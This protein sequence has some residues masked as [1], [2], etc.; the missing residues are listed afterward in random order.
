MLLHL[1]R[2]LLAVLPIAL[3]VS[4]ICFLLVYLAP[5]DPLQTLL[6]P[7]ADAETVAKLKQ[8]YGLDRPLPLQYL[9]WLWQVM[10]GDLGQSIATGRPVLSE[11]RRSLGNTVLL[12]A[13]AVL[14]AFPLAMLLGTIAGY[15]SGGWM[16]RGV[17]G[18]AILGVS[19]PNYWLGIVLVILFS[20]ELGWLPA[21]GMGPD[22]SG[23]FNP[24]HWEQLRHIILPVVTLSMIPVGIIARTAR[25]S[26][27]EVMAQDFVTTL[28]ANGLPERRVLRHA[29]KNALPSVL[30]VMGLQ[31][32]ALMGGSILVETVFAW[33]GTGFLLS[34]AILTRDIPVLQGTILVLAMIFVATNLAVDLFQSSLDPRI[35]RG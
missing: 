35:K 15:R 25:A 32:G 3:G 34:K 14:I 19:L 24:L 21:S 23:T 1:Q 13:V 22:G 30:A 9:A 33:P 31:F 12:A 29:V 27:S 8:L 10:G 17:T 16:D 4:M 5:G 7:D 6:P 18:T 28:R 2:R 26:I 11:I 20:V